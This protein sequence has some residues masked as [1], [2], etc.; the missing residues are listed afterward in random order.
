MNQIDTIMALADRLGCS[1]EVCQALRAAIEQELTHECRKAYIAGQR[2]QIE[3]YE[4]V[5]QP[6]PMPP[7]I[8]YDAATDVLTIHGKRYSSA[9]F[10]EDGFLAPPGTVLRIE[11]GPPDVVTLT[12][13]QPQREWVGLTDEEVLAIADETRVSVP[14]SSNETGKW[15]HYSVVTQPDK[16][17]ARAIEAKLRERLDR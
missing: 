3:Q 1:E 8:T 6:Q 5:P 10:G 9:M 7:W 16:D 17:F 2:Y 15:V 14:C 4:A 11:Q 13:V 12:T